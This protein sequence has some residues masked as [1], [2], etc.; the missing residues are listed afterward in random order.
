MNRS[1]VSLPRPIVRLATVA[2]ISLAVVAA[3]A[4][5]ASAH[6]TVSSPDAVAGGY[7]T[8][9]LNVPDESDSASTTRIR[10]QI[11]DSTPLAQVLVQPVP[12]WTATT[13]PRT[14]AKP[15]TDDD[16]NTITSAVSVID[17]T[18]TAGGIAPGQFQQF[19]LSAG[20]FPKAKSLAFNVVQTYSDG[21]EAAWIEPTVAGQPEP[22]HPAPV[23]SLT[24]ASSS[25][26]A[27]A[28]TSSEHAGHEAAASSTGGSS[29]PAPLALFLSLLGIAIGLAG[30]ALGWRAG[31]RT[32]SS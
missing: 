21:T 12:G 27:A 19:T 17:F 28:T 2:G 32:V 6:V 29:S 10:V 23:L 11:P 31:R 8:V 9:V 30:V 16:G 7:G 14:L 26:A 20:A 13:T 25:A 5:V 1:S 3:G 18:A 24:G 22:E 15:L 4:G